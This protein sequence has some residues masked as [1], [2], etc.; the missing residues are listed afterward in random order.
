[1]PKN[2][3]DTSRSD[4]DKAEDTDL[5]VEQRLAALERE[6]DKWKALARKHEQR[7][8]A[9]A[10]K[11]KEFDEKLSADDKGKTALDLL[12]ERAEAAEKKLSERDAAD[13][14]KKLRKEV[15]KEYDVDPKALRGTTREELED[16]AATLQE[17]YPKADK[18]GGPPSKGQGDRGGSVHKEGELSADDIV[19]Q[20]T[21]R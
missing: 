19:Q 10:D 14:A 17:L 3:D 4:K 18:A 2:K 12:L 11:A 9:N 7:A 20:A 15:A 16:H 13:A 21:G 5:T 8:N 1:M 6:R